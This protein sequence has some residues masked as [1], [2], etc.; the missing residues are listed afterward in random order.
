MLGTSPARDTH[1]GIRQLSRHEHL[2]VIYESDAE[3]LDALVLFVKVALE[4]RN[5]FFYVADSAGTQDVR[6]ALRAQGV[7]VDRAAERGAFTLAT[8]REVYLAAGE[9]DP[10][11]MI[12]LAKGAAAQAVRDGFDGL[13][14]AGEMSWALGDRT[15]IERVLHYEE[16]VNAHI[17]FLPV[18]AVCQYD[19]RRFPPEV[20]R[21]VIRTHPLVAVGGRICRNFY[22]VPPGDLTGPDR[23]AHDVDRLLENILERERAEDALR[24][25]ERRL[26]TAGRLASVGTLAAGIGHELSNPLAYVVSNLEFAAERLASSE[27]GDVPE[28]A[29]A[30]ADALDGAVR[31]RDVVRGLRRFAGPVPAAERAPQDVAAEIKAAAAIA[32]HQV[33]ARAALV[34]ELEPGLPAVVAGPNEIAQVVVN[35]VVNAAQAIPEGHFLR[36]RVRVRAR[37]AGGRVVIEV[38]DTGV[39]IPPE[40]LERVFDPFFTTKHGSGTGLGLAICQGIVGAAGGT[41]GVESAV[42]R[43]TTLRVELPATP[44]VPRARAAGGPGSS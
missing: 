13:G 5:R 7:D 32:R 30:V 6:Q 3:K 1:T 14:I 21:D 31:M 17:P 36:N 8:D 40:I 16:L 9:F 18:A 23:N 25:S 24:A 27:P 41:L 29:R 37:S 11:A 28:I 10:E 22:Y 35:L 33:E 4:Q 44:G 20:I 42:G 26:Q 38:S 2:C 43:G 34:L 19:R 39:G 15:R 12:A